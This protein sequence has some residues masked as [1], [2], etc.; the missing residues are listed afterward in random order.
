MY[1]EILSNEELSALLTDNLSADSREPELPPSTARTSTYR[2]DL[3]ETVAYLQKSVHLLAK[4]LEQVEEELD[5]LRR[6]RNRANR[7]SSSQ[8]GMARGE[9]SGAAAGASATAE[10]LRTPGTEIRYVELGLP[11]GTASQGGEAGGASVGV[12]W[13]RNGSALAG[14]QARLGV[15]DS[16]YALPGTGAPYGAPGAGSGG[17]GHGADGPG[18]QKAAAATSFEPRSVRHGRKK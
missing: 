1:K 4:R 6:L 7:E 12:L 17:G 8:S 18:E 3:G 15:P 2:E 5:H 10:A 16:A 11:P 13:S 14:M 9:R